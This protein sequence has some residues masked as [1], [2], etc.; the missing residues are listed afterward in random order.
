[1]TAGTNRK[2]VAEVEGAELADEQT[3]TLTAA[4]A[5]PADDKAKDKAKA[6]PGKGKR[7]GGGGSGP[8]G[9]PYST[10]SMPTD[11]PADEGGTTEPVPTEPV[12]TGGPY[13]THS[14]PVGTK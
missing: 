6:K 7:K 3:V 1:M 2:R 13:S 4:K 12:P 9:G 14:D 8:E 10:H 11:E 5:K